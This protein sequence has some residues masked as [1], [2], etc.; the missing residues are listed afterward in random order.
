MA[1]R[2]AGFQPGTGA[3][4][5]NRYRCVRGGAVVERM[6]S[7]VGTGVFPLRQ[8]F[9]GKEAEDHSGGEFALAVNRLADRGE[10]DQGCDG[11]I[12]D[13]DDGDVVRN[14]EAC[15]FDGS[16]RP[17]CDFIGMGVNGCWRVLEAQKGIQGFR[18]SGETPY[19]SLRCQEASRRLAGTAGW[20]ASGF[21]AR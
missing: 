6:T 20:P 18:S 2:R 21:R 1:S 9:S 16:L 3:R 7:W 15:A 5:E 19:S 10:V 11:V 12:V 13:P 14:L 4:A 8:V 17:H